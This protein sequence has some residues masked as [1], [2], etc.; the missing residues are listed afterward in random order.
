MKFRTNMKPAT[1]GI[2]ATIAVLLGVALIFMLRSDNTTITRFIL[3]IATIL[4]GSIT[5][6]ESLWKSYKQTLSGAGKLKPREL[7]YFLSAIVAGIAIFLAASSLITGNSF[8]L[9]NVNTTTW[10]YVLNIG[11][12]IVHIFI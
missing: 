8:L 4:F 1:K 6:V 3:P 12:A 9:W 11:F 5:L 7:I 2:L 10:I